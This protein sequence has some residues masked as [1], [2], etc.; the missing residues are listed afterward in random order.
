MFSS[1]GEAG[2]AEGTAKAKSFAAIVQLLL[3][4]GYFR[5]RLPALSEFDRVV[6]GLC[7]AIVGSTCRAR[8]HAPSPPGATHAMWVDP[9]CCRCVSGACGCC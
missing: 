3:S 5:A 8:G 4:A 2:G 9:G 6:G 1:S 7:W